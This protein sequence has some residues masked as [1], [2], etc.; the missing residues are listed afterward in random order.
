VAGTSETPS[1]RLSNGNSAS[2]HGAADDNGFIKSLT[3]NDMQPE[4]QSSSVWAF[5]SAARGETLAEMLIGLLILANTV[6]VFLQLELEGRAAGA[7]S[8]SGHGEVSQSTKLVFE[9]FA[10]VFN[11]IFLIELIAKLFILRQRYFHSRFNVFDAVVVI[12]NSADLYILSQIGQ[13]S[14]NVSFLRVV[15]MLRLA[16]VLRVIR[17]LELFQQLR[18]LMTTI[19]LSFMS[20]FWSMMILAIFILLGSLLLCQVVQDFIMDDTADPDMLIWVNRYYGTSSKAFYTMFEA[21]F[22]GCWPTYARPLIEQINAW[23][24][25]FFVVYVTFVVFTLIRIIYA[26][27]LKD[28]MQ[29]AASDTDQVV[30]DKMRETKALAAKLAGMFKEADVTGDGYLSRQEFEDILAYP[31]VKTWLSAIGVNAE[32]EQNLF[33]IL[34]DGQA[35]DNRISSEEFLDGIMRLKGKA[36]EQDLLRNVRDTHRILKHVE[37]LRTEVAKLRNPWS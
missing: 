25:L 9:V 8:V 5:V 28:T 16:R 22:S 23:F 33:D 6:V 2:S 37:A 24:A 18:V 13:D 10:H 35:A 14:T 19:V 27:L 11:A 34:E 3:H 21:T 4:L 30:R 36:N 12:I 1:R 7:R 31:K 29:A 26:L 15:R 17:T 32:D 20:I